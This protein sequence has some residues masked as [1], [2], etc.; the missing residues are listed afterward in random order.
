MPSKLPVLKE[1]YR[2]IGERKLFGEGT[3]EELNSS[4]HRLGN[5]APSEKSKDLARRIVAV[6][7]GKGTD[8]DILNF[9]QI[10]RE[11]QI[12]SQIRIGD[13]FKFLR[14]S[15]T[16]MTSGTNRL[17]VARFDRNVLQYSEFLEW[18]EELADT[19]EI[20]PNGKIQK[21]P[22][23]VN[24]RN[25]ELLSRFLELKNREETKAKDW[26]RKYIGP[27]E[28][29]SIIS[30]EIVFGTVVL[31]VDSR[32][33]MPDFISLN[34]ERGSFKT[35]NKDNPAII[36]IDINP[37]KRTNIDVKTSLVHEL[38]HSLFDMFRRLMIT[39]LHILL[40]VQQ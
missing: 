39:D 35:G 8:H 25:R 6:I 5:K 16:P 37:N 2:L 20:D 28:A 14:H 15:K 27:A 1:R 33:S 9:K 19:I 31:L 13:F 22:G 3:V 4:L 30:K 24:P 38:R 17:K 29:N 12:E 36:I 10:V 21:G 7:N 18:V 40:L 11:F 32:K 26:L 23:N 34:K